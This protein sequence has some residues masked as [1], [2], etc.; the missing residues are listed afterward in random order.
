MW[1]DAGPTQRP[2]AGARER[3]RRKHLTG[4]PRF[5][6]AQ[7]RMRNIVANRAQWI[8]CKQCV[9]LGMTASC[10]MSPGS[11]DQY[12]CCDRCIICGGSINRPLL[13]IQSYKSSRPQNWSTAKTGPPPKPNHLLRFYG[14]EGST[15]ALHNNAMNF[16]HG[17]VWA[18]AAK[19]WY[20]HVSNFFVL[21]MDSQKDLNF[22]VLFGV[23]T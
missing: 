22:E 7:E 16:N 8:Y 2:R 9:V 6:Q 17:A 23:H 18:F 14:G 19:V 20:K 21:S 1:R 11:A 15:E 12:R 13:N 3:R 5:V 4:G 10:Y